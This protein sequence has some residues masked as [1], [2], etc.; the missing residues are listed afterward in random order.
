MLKWFLIGCL[1]TSS[2]WANE[3]GKRVYATCVA[4]HG[5]QAE[6]KVSQN[7]PKLSGQYSWYLERQM[8]AFK[9]KTRT[10]EYAQMM[11]PFASGLTSEEIKAVVDYIS[12]LDSKK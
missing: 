2:V 3:L 4:C 7:A 8:L 5:M 11:Y 1:F 6:G 10:G 9:N 12:E